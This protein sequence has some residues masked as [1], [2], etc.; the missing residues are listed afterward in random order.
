MLIELHTHTSDHSPCGGIKAV[1]LLH[2]VE[3]LGVQGVVLTDH[4]YLWSDEEL[5]SLRRESG[6]SDDFLLFSGQEVTTA[7]V[8]DVL[9]Y[10]AT[11]AIHQSIFLN[12]LRNKYPEAALVW[13]HPYR[14]NRRPSSIELF[15]AAFD[16][17]E[18]VNP[19]QWKE[20]NHAGIADWHDWGFV[21]TGGT[22][23]HYE[24]PPGFYPTE[25]PIIIHSMAELIASIKDGQCR[26]ILDHP[27]Q[28]YKQEELSKWALEGINSRTLS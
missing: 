16:A 15:N 3:N 5:A 27:Y 18:I 22:D 12:D 23:I 17:I 8:G 26:P 11:E 19:R 25:F 6:I 24:N 10:G 14:G 28:I 9:V 4:H 1:D 20:G 2:F 21:A 13:A 7:D